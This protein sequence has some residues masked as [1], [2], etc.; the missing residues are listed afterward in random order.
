[1]QHLSLLIR[2]PQTRQAMGNAGRAHVVREYDLEQ[3]LRSM[4]NIY[5]RIL[6]RNRFN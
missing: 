4:E 5:G 1:V 6:E 2:Q 3:Q